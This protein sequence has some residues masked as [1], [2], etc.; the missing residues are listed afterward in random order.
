LA[1][2]K[3]RAKNP[4]KM[5]FLPEFAIRLGEEA[6]SWG[7]ITATAIKSSPP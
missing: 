5:T 2:P 4:K 1:K 6:I 7:A 3:A